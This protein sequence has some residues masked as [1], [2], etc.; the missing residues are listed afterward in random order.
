MSSQP[1]GPRA[2]RSAEGAPACRAAQSRAAVRPK[3]C[4]T[5]TASLPGRACT[6]PPPCGRARGRDDAL[7]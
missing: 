6:Q 7:D 2:P 3:S 1:R 4:A 5:S